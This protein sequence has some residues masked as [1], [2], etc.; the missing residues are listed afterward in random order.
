MEA[1]LHSLR[2][3]A[4]LTHVDFENNSADPE[5]VLPAVRDMS[6]AKHFV[7]LGL[8]QCAFTLRP[9]HPDPRTRV[10][11]ADAAMDAAA[12]LLHEALAT[13][14]ALTQL[15]VPK[16]LTAR[17]MAAWAVADGM[18]S[19]QQLR[20]LKLCDWNRYGS[21]GDTIVSPSAELAAV[22]AASLRAPSQLERL[23]LGR[24]WGVCSALLA[25]LPHLHGLQH[26]VTRCT[27]EDA[28]GLGLCLRE[29]AVLTFL[30]VYL[31]SPDHDDEEQ[32]AAAQFAPHLPAATWLQ[33]LY[34]P[35]N[36]VWRGVGA[37]D[38]LCGALRS[39]QS[40][41]E[42]AVYDQHLRSGEF[43]QV[44]VAALPRLQRE[45]CVVGSS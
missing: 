43:D 32:T 25:A 14:T 35:G 31:P 44:A 15:A 6:G 27:T 33:V 39:M 2:G 45:Q 40:L 17:P 26:L 11:T 4:Q 20:A 13:L 9:G 24:G 28:E 42:F 29:L 8:L 23:E 38:A 1:L 22:L 3:K 10:M 5:K 18:S 21:R 7:H 30:A 19:L 34:L 12:P 16:G 37:I 41:R 36:C